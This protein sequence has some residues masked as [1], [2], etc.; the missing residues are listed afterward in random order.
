MAIVSH[1]PH[2][3]AASLVLTAAGDPLALALGAGSFH[4]GTRVAA[5]PPELMAAICGGNADAVDDALAEV[6]EHL[7]QAAIALDSKDPIS[8]LRP[9]F[10]PASAVRAAWPP[11]PSEPAELPAQPEVLL[12]LGRAGG[13]ITDVSADR[14]SVVAVRPHERG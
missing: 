12:R 9:W 4:D 5:S 7:R 11:A 10:A 2:L 1:V 14:R 8:K 3:L 13:W 6:V